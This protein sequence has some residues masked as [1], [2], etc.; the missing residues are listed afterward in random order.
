MVDRIC[1]NE[2]IR[3]HKIYCLT[4]FVQVY[5]AEKFEPSCVNH[6]DFV[7]YFLV[8]GYFALNN[9]RMVYNSLVVNLACIDLGVFQIAIKIV[10]F[11]Q[12]ET[13]S[14]IGYQIEK[15]KFLGFVKFVRVGIALDQITDQSEIFLRQIKLIIKTVLILL[16]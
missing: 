16:V 1:R 3:N 11:V 13:I 14:L 12:I 5:L 7:V 8:I 15:E 2:S 4:C 9:R 10:Q 6:I